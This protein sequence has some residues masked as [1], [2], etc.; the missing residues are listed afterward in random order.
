MTARAKATQARLSHFIRAPSLGPRYR[1]REQHRVEQQLE[2]AVRLTA[3][4]RPES[5]KDHSA[6]IHWHLCQRRLA[7]QSITVLHVSGSQGLRRICGQC[8][9]RATNVEGGATLEV[10]LGGVR[11]AEKHH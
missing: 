10:D 8:S 5:E 3:E 4:L 6:S 2:G 1:G 9:G 7:N 11:D